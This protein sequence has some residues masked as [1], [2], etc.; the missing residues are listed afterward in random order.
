MN[1]RLM[2]PR[3]LLKINNTLKMDFRKISF[4]LG[5]TCVL[6]SSCNKEELEV[7]PQESGSTNSI[8][9]EFVYISAPRT[10]E[11]DLR[12]GIQKSKMWK[13]GQT[14]KIKFVSGSAANKK[15]AQKAFCDWS[16]YANINFVFVESGED[17]RVGIDEPS[18]S[19]TSG[20][21]YIGTDCKY[22][23]AQSISISLTWAKSVP[24]SNKDRNALHEIGHSLGFLHEHQVYPINWN[25]TEVDKYYHGI[26]YTDDWIYTNIY[27]N[28]GTTGEAAFVIKD[29]SSIMTYTIPSN[30]TT[31]GFSTSTNWQLSAG[32]KTIA[33]SAYPYD[34]TYRLVRTIRKNGKHFY[35]KFGEILTNT[36]EDL[37]SGFEGF[38]C[39]IFSS[40]VDGSVPLYRYHNSK[41]GDHFY[42]TN[43]SEL[44]S[45]KNNYAY[46]SV[47]G[48]VYPSQ[49]S[50]SIPLYRYFNTKTS[51]HFYTTNW[52][53]LGSGK[54]NYKYEGIQCYVLPIH[55]TR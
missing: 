9:N 12:S 4:L 46:E 43:W 8:E 55:A 37:W 39:K 15:I 24:E 17:Y 10:I 13:N 6:F 54:N 2:F 48:Y 1:K 5:T 26:G 7:S 32:D 35:C 28:W 53:E 18:G 44:G 36:K 19:Y 31:D 45:G 21:S 34:K 41:T 20:W 22:Q 30:F 42:T 27:K 16:Q 33:Q 23:T 11:N 14:I 52:A 47:Q 49:V 3:T 38:Q 51:E 25:R 40:K 29:K 50:G